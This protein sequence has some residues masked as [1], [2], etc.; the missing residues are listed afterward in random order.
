MARAKTQSAWNT[1]KASQTSSSKWASGRAW[2]ACLRTET[3]DRVIHLAAQV[4]VRYSLQNPHVY[5]D[6][7]IVGFVN[8]LE[9]CT[10]RRHE[11]GLRLKLQRVRPQH[12]N[13]VKCRFSNYDGARAGCTCPAR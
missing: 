12:Q 5:V 8:I 3:F 7:N 1:L 6:S 2:P 9:G 4:G 13:A 10:Q 11:P